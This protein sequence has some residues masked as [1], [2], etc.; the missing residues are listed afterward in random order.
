MDLSSKVVA[1]VVFF[2]LALTAVLP[3]CSSEPSSKRHAMVEKQIAAQG[4]SDARV[5]AAMRRVPRHLFVPPEL[6]RV[7]YSD[8][9]LP[10][11]GGQTISQPYIVAFMTEAAEIS[12]ADRCLE[13]GTGSGYQAAVLAEL[14]A[15]TYSIEYLPEVAAFG[16]AN[17]DRTGY[18]GRVQL[19]VGDGYGGWPERAPFDVIIVTAAPGKVPEPLLAQLSVHGKLVIPIGP[20]GGRQRL[21]RWTRVRPGAT[22]AAFDREALLSVQF[23]PFL[24]SGE[25]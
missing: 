13:V 22:E 10:I 8:G 7:A 23:V 5:L 25:R 6:E 3:A 4:V 11:P 21:E 16:R 9:P 20:E 18:L 2:E 24:G 17:L 12:P 19:R 1:T 15:E 14:C